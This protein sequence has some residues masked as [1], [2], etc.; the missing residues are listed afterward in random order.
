MSEENN[1][2]DVPDIET[3]D[4][5]MPDIQEKPEIKD[6]VEGAFKFAFIGSGQGGGQTG[7][8]VLQNWLSKGLC[9]QYG[10]TRPSHA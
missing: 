1:I 3:P 7:T 6:E 9:H 8:A 4:I 2:T 5:P 10:C